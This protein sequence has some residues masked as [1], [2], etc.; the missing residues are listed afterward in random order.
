MSARLASLIRGSR[1]ARLVAATLAVAAL[2][3][4]GVAS[5]H[6]LGNFTINHYNGIRVS[7]DAVLVD[8]VLDMAEIPTFSERNAMDT[9][10]DGQV[11]SAEAAAYESARCDAIRADLD[12][13]AGGS[14]LSLDVV[15]RGL[16]FPQGQGAPTLRLVCVYRAALPAALGTAATSFTFTDR[17]Y[18][19]RTGWRE[20]VVQGDASTIASSD[21]P[22]GGISGRLTSYPADLLSTPSNQASAGWSAVA[23]GLALAPFSVPDAM[24]IGGSTVAP[25]PVTTPVSETAAVPGGIAELGADV[26]A[27][28]QA[29]DLT[30]WLIAVSLLVAGGLGALHALSPGHGKTVMAA[31]LVG[32]RGSAR[33]ALGLGLVVTVSHTIGVLALGLLT[34]SFSAVIPPERLYPILGLV[35]GAIVIGIGAWLILQRVRAIQAGR[36]AARAVRLHA[37]AHEHGHEHAHGHG[38][39]AAHAHE[40]G[41]GH[42][43]AHGLELAHG[44][45]HDHEPEHPR[46]H[47][48]EHAHEDEAAGWH[49]HG[50]MRHTHL[51]PAGSTVSRRGLVALGLAGGMVP[52]VSALILLLGSVSLGRPAY[53]I[54]LTVAFGV[55]MAVVL[56]GI[57]L[58]LVYARG[59]VERVASGSRSIG[60]TS[61]LPTATA[62]VVLAAGAVMTAQAL[63]LVR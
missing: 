45:A 37:Q 50:G 18:S 2:L 6:P 60:L 31:Y 32:T 39:E 55:G 15:Q 19:Q 48:D 44:H 21:A 12:L 8:H 38:Q 56:S 51:P 4:P 62:V 41:H 57:G 47:A 33:Q 29:R 13:R 17:S 27:L 9:D 14:A 1:R 36:T 63:A 42:E 11:G 28:F 40:Q 54:V 16:S 30:P 5:A 58:A 61:W 10:G 7:T 34:L 59:F 23:G 22:A 49:S 46:D 20:I 35:S 24:L 25:P 53:G 3:L 52:S 26:S 43:S